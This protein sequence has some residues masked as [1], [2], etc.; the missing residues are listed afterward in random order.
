MEETLNIIPHK[1]TIQKLDRNKLNNHKSFVIWLTGLSGSGKSTIASS[2]ERKLHQL[3]VRTYI[4][5]GDNVR[6]GLNKDLDFT[7]KS[8]EENIRR[9]AELS[10]LFIDSGT[11]VISAFISPFEKDRAGVKSTVGTNN[12]VEVHV[13][14]PLEICE[15]RDVKGLYKMARNGEIS[16]FTGISSPFE[17]PTKPD[18][19]VNTHFQ[20][21]NDCTADVMKLINQKLEL[22]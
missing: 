2:V 7:S 21:L 17:V 20:T 22:K 18:V 4:L 12:F 13:D 9:I 5:D 6:N 19:I 8:R 16:N 15:Q 1:H 10:N 14:C 3:G 11:V